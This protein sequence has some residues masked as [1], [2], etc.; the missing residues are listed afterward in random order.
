MF[1][2]M[3][4]SRAF[5]LVFFIAVLMLVAMLGAQSPNWRAYSYPADGFS[6]AFPAEPELQKREIPT[7]A[8]SFELRSYLALD[9]ESAL[10][11]GVCDYGAAVVGRD[12]QAILQGAKSGALA[13]T[14]AHALSERRIT[15]GIYPGVAFE[16]ENSSMHFSAR[17]YLVG[18]TL[19]QILTATPLSKPYPEAVRF[20]DSF[21]LIPRTSN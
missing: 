17:I 20:L 4:L 6:A 19:Y 13:N 15:L 5:R 16:A 2:W 8:G 11:V 3:R 1:P 12:P 21:Q 7:D 18:S 9:G 14:S 10:F